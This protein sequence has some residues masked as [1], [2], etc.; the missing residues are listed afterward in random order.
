[1]EEKT[2]H[3]VIKPGLKLTNSDGTIQ[4]F[5]IIMQI[6]CRNA[7]LLTKYINTTWL[8]WL[9]TRKGGKGY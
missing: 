9:T 8:Y 2:E 1:M 5:L 4:A 7:K 3:K 6:M